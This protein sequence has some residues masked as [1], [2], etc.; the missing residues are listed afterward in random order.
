MSLSLWACATVPAG[1]GG[2]VW[3][4]SGDVPRE[5]LGEGQHFIGPF[6]AVQVYDLRAQERNEDLVGL[7]ADGSP[8]EAGASVVTYHH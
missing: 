4:P 2:V 1:A 5:A 6:A 3:S 8:V 7:T